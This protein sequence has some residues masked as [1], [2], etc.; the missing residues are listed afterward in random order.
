MPPQPGRGEKLKSSFSPQ[1][2]R[3][4]PPQPRGPVPQTPARTNL[5]LHFFFLSLPFS[6]SYLPRPGDRINLAPPHRTSSNPLPQTLGRRP[7]GQRTPPPGRPAHTATI[8]AGDAPHR[9]ADSLRRKPPRQGRGRR[10][11]RPPQ[12]RGS[13]S[14]RRCGGGPSRR[15]R[16]P[17][18]PAATPE[19]DEGIPGT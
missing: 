3:V 5:S 11:P 4:R 13:Q 17:I 2:G 1:P 14:R 12:Q 10:P 6:C 19:P 9:A 15:R 18:S 7:R 16:R 8:E